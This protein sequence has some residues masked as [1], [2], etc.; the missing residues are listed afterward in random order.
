[1]ATIASAPKEIQLNIFRNITSV[2]Q[3]AQCRLVCKQWDAAAEMAMFGKKITLKTELQA[4]NLYAHLCKD[5]RKGSMIRHLH[6]DLKGAELPLIYM[7]LLNV[8]LSSNIERLTGIVQTDNFFTALV[9]IAESKETKFSKLKELPT[10]TDGVHCLAAVKAMIYFK[11]TT[12]LVYSANYSE[13]D[14]L[15]LMG[16]LGNLTH[17]QLRGSFRSFEELDNVLSR[18]KHLKSLEIVD[19][20]FCVLDA[21][22]ISK[23]EIIRDECE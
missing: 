18:C 7:A 1:M 4:I 22:E 14:T 23:Y 12:T 11:K 16:E 21:W 5:I 2:S 6:F 9:D 13:A 3:I 10:R 8:A 20:N 19:F 15:D 17:L